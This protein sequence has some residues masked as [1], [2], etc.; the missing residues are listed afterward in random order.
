MIPVSH[1]DEEIPF[2]FDLISPDPYFNNYTEVN[3]LSGS[4]SVYYFSN[5]PAQGNA[6]QDNEQNPLLFPG[7]VLANHSLP[8]RPKRF[9]H[10]H[11][12]ALQ[13]AQVDV[14]DILR[15]ETMWQ[16][17][18]PAV[19]VQS[20]AMDLSALP[21]GCY[22]L[23]IG[24]EQVMD[25]YLTNA[26]TPYRFGI[27]DIFPGGPGQFSHIPDN[28]R[29]IDSE[30]QIIPKRFSLNLNSRP[31][32]WRYYIFKSPGEDH[33]YENFQVSGISKRVQGSDSDE[34]SI[35]F[36]EV[37][38]TLIDGRSARVFVS[39]KAIPLYEKPGDVYEITFKSD[40]PHER[41]ASAFKLPY[42]RS[43]NTRLVE[44]AGKRHMYSD[45]FV[46]L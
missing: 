46:Y 31:T 21:D 29:T 7:D 4:E 13:N 6:P 35:T 3:P 40:L 20:I 23:Q 22:R 16:T 25:F 17:K 34:I 10:T 37:E 18:T 28:H 32:Y 33:L 19:D 12:A 24:R 41:G 43:E 44:I 5:L 42:A 27:I 1:F 39:N 30:G 38:Q 2:S 14:I 9:T 45:V 11:D 36:T 15:A 8:V 26:I